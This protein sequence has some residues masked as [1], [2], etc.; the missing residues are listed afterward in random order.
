MAWLLP[1]AAMGGTA[2]WLAGRTVRRRVTE[3]CLATLLIVG[4]ATILLLAGARERGEAAFAAIARANP[5][6]RF[7]V[8]N[9]EIDNEIIGSLVDVVSFFMEIGQGQTA[10]YFVDQGTRFLEVEAP[11]RLDS[12]LQMVDALALRHS[13]GW[14]RLVPEQS[15]EGLLAWYR[16]A[17]IYR[18]AGAEIP[19]YSGQIL[20]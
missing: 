6:A 4:C 17:L 14:Y 1:L 11:D 3:W 9:Y 19:D 18:E 5:E 8:R 7:V 10:Q 12:F 2:V 15:H 16:Q 13:L 20:Y